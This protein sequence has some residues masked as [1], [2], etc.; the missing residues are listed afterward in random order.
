MGQRSDGLS[1]VVLRA[2]LSRACA[3]TESAQWNSQPK[4]RRLPGHGGREPR[5]LRI[6]SA[7]RSPRSRRSPRA[8]SS[9]IPPRARRGREC[10]RCGP[11]VLRALPPLRRRAGLTAPSARGRSGRRRAASRSRPR[12][13]SALRDAARGA[14]C[15]M[16]ARL[17]ARP[18][19][20]K[21][22]FDR[23]GRRP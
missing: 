15:A 20:H 22:G 8:C 18:G 19:A 14:T 11:A 12:R 4:S 23:P 6:G 2:V 17:P 16:P 10:A 7:G 21:F 5:L 13:R 1:R 9:P 3:R